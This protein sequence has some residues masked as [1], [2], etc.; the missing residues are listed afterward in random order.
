MEAMQ[1]LIRTDVVL[2]DIAE[3]NSRL[4]RMSLYETRLFFAAPAVPW[5]YQLLAYAVG[6]RNG[7]GVPWPLLRPLSIELS[8]IE[9]F[10]KWQPEFSGAPAAQVAGKLQSFRL[11]RDRFPYG[12]S[13]PKDEVREHYNAVV[14]AWAA[15]KG[16]PAPISL[17]PDAPAPSSSPGSP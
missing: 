9:R 7:A 2:F 13:L 3:G 1:R 11:V 6:G 15:V 4:C 14:T 16:V 17:D 5:F 10:W 12:T 8:A